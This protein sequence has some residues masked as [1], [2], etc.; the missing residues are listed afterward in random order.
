MLRAVATI[1]LLTFAIPLAG[2]VVE[3]PGRPGWCA[4]H[5]YRCR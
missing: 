1:M 4:Y 5:P 2:C 3:G